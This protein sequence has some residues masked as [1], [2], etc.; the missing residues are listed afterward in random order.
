MSFQI[1]TV[2]IKIKKTHFHFIHRHAFNKKLYNFENI[3]DN[4]IET[5]HNKNYKLKH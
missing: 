2:I 3:C 4:I 5:K 1:H